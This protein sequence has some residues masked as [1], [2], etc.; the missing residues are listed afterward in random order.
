MGADVDQ[1]ADPKLW[2]I[3]FVSRRSAARIR[4]PASR[5][6]VIYLMNVTGVLDFDARRAAAI[7]L[8][9]SSDVS[10]LA[11]TLEETGVRL[12]TPKIRR[13]RIFGVHIERSE[14]VAA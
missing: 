5:P 3:L 6:V 12:W 14:S 8:N 11:W 13:R 4:S 7:A 1:M 2:I 10:G 9:A